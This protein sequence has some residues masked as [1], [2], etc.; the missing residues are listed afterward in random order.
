M[1][2]MSH[3]LCCVFLLLINGCLAGRKPVKEATHHS[4]PKTSQMIVFWALAYPIRNETGTFHVLVNINVTWKIMYLRNS[5]NLWLYKGDTCER[6][7]PWEYVPGLLQCMRLKTA[8]TNTC[9]F[10]CLKDRRWRRNGKDTKGLCFVRYCLRVV[11]KWQ[12]EIRVNPI[13]TDP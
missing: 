1:Q 6:S 12:N 2:H 7:S 9:M 10:V 5:N 11:A 8:K 3:F 4:D 13:F